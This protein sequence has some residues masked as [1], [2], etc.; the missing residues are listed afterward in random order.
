LSGKFAFYGEDMRNALE[1]AREELLKIYKLSLEIVYEDSAAEAKLASAAAK[2]LIEIDRVPI[3]IGG[4]GSTANL[5]VAPLMESTQTLF[6]PVSANPKL[7]EAGEYIFKLHP[8]YDGEITRMSRYLY[9]RGFRK[10]AVLYDSSSD[11]QIFAKDFFSREFSRLGGEVAATEGSDSQ[12]VSDFRSQLIKLKQ[13]KPDALYFFLIEKVAGQA[14]RQAREMG[15]SQPIFG[16]TAFASPE[17]FTTAGKVAEGVMIT[18]QPF[19]CQGKLLM[20]D[21]CAR[22]KQ[23]FPGRQPTQYGAHAFDAAQI[24]IKIAREA[25]FDKEKIRQGL[26]AVKGYHG[27]SGEFSFDAEGNIRD[28]DF[29]FRVVK[30]GKF[31]D[32]PV[33]NKY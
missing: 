19:A 18:D 3:I 27:V 6:L 5:A 14:V 2:K 16:T 33:E 22:Y 10:P 9:E 31:V 26:L 28:K 21:Y 1:L 30:D 8:D 13:A 23:K 4:P 15:L 17:F 7:N 12:V 11:T 20:R 25:D 32:F 29:V 24:I